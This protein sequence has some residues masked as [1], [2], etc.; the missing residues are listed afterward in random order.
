[1]P[2]RKHSEVDLSGDGDE[3]LNR[4]KATRLGH[5]FE[6]GSQLLFRALKTARGFERQKLGRRQKTAKGDG[7]SKT[8]ERLEKEVHALKA[9]D[10]EEIAQR[11]LLKQLNKT[12][13]IAESPEFVRLEKSINASF[14]VGPG[15][16]DPAE[17]NV[18]ARLFKSNPVQTALPDILTDIRTL[19]GVDEIPTR[20]Q[21]QKHVKK[22]A[23]QNE[24]TAKEPDE[25]QI[26]T[27]MRSHKMEGRNSRAEDYLNDVNMDDVSDDGDSLDLSQ[28]DA[29]LASASEGSNSEEE[30]FG[31]SRIKITSPSNRDNHEIPDDISISSSPASSI[32]SQNPSESP[33][34]TSV[35]PPKTHKK[36][37]SDEQRPKNTTFLPSLMMGGYWSGSES[38]PEEDEVAAAAAGSRP[39]RKNRMG[40]QARR[41]LWEK[42]YG[43]RAKHLQEQEKNSKKS[44]N[45]DSGW[46]ARRG[47][48]D[49]ND[50]PKWAAGAG[51]RGI[52]S[53]GKRDNHA[54]DSGNGKA[55]MTNNKS[56][57]SAATA[58]LHPSWEAARKA[59]QQKAQASFQG[60]K[61]TFD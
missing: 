61:I 5:K 35:S 43:A 11:Y 34:P 45:K 53:L 20:K 25:P 47:A 15:P 24:E 50:K 54:R 9:L 23:T 16:R 33:L 18:T 13:R 55:T 42:K 38:D 17:A 22:E 12:K 7:D 46:D 36:E 49:E 21:Q 31:Y 32:I 51:K 8:L 40:Q 57:S 39:Q 26:E 10:L 60:K 6:R 27:D 52:S 29:R 48:T 37:K 19:L 41:A 44:K 1:M 3:K 30:E 56:S 4:V 28:F 14:D 2:K 59:K 58:G